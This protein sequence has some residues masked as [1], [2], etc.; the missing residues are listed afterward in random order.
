MNVKGVLSRR[1][2]PHT[3]FGAYAPKEE[4]TPGTKILGKESNVRNKT[5]RTKNIPE[6]LPHVLPNA[7]GYRCVLG[8][9][10]SIPYDGKQCYR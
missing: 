2:V 8:L 3:N 4:V 5:T 1:D 6:L 7:R 9:E 10:D